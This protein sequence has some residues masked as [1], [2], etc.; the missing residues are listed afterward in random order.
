[1]KCRNL[2]F[3]TASLLENGIDPIYI[4]E[5]K[6]PEL[7]AQVMQKRREA[8]FG[9]NQPATSESATSKS[10][11]RSRYKYIQQ[12]CTELLT[13][14]GVVTITSMGEAEAA[15][16]GLNHQGVVEG[17]ITIDGDAFLYGAKTVY[18]NLST[19]IHNF[20][21]QEYSMDVIETRLN[22]SRDKLIAMAILFGCDYLPDGVPGVG[23][24]SA[25]RVISTWKNGQALEILKSWH[26]EEM[27]EDSIPLRPSHCSQCK[28]PGKQCNIHVN[29]QCKRNLNSQC[30]HPG[31]LRTHAKSGCLL[32]K[33][34]SGGGCEPSN[35]ACLCPW[36]ENEVRYEELAM[37]GK[38]YRLKELD[39]E[40]IFDEFKNEVH[41][42]RN[43]GVIP[44][45]QMPCIQKFLNIATKK[46][47]WEP[48]YAAEKILPLLSRWII[49][50]G[51]RQPQNQLPVT[52]LRILK[53]R[54]KV[55][56]KDLCIS[57]IVYSYF[58]I[59]LALSNSLHST[60]F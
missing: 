4:L 10:T 40:K 57:W 23:K 12:E 24:E 14:L 58:Y 18:R 48:Q 43:G 60:F 20:V 19:D 45:W 17:C 59:F 31:S 13:A 6:A 42:Q 33:S 3:R 5:G 54:V 37:R 39:L 22:L 32:C 38:L 30:K 41:I 52:P 28:H 1:M 53:K 11:G 21:C 26:S 16:A 29:I 47:K 15:C 46:L 9:S 25:L 44:P 56:L 55:A 49:I 34:S 50:H 36:H 27:D 7:K 8:R 2:F 35:K 51:N